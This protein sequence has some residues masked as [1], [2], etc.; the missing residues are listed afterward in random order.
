MLSQEEL[1][2]QFPPDPIEITEFRYC[3]RWYKSTKKANKEVVLVYD[4]MVQKVVYRGMST[5]HR[6]HYNHICRFYGKGNCDT[7]REVDPKTYRGM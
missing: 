4:K 7:P 1:N 5:S 6:D 2:L 3:V